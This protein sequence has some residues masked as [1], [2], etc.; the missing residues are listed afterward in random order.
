VQYV[1]VYRET[2]DIV[3]AGPAGDWRTDEENHI[4]STESGQPVCR[5]DDLVVVLRK[6]TSAR[7]ANFGCMI[8]PRQDNLAK[9]QEF[10]AKSAQTTIRSE[11]RRAW[12]EGL[13]SRLGKQD[14][15]VYGLDP[16]TRVARVMVEADYRMKLV[17]MGLEAGVP[18]VKSYLAS[19][20]VPAGQSPPPMGVLRWWF[21]LNYDALLASQDHQAFALRGQ[22]VKVLSENERLTAAGQRVHTGQSEALCLQFARSFTEHFE[23]LCVKYPIYADLRNIFDLALVAALVREEDLGNKVGWHMVSFGNPKAYAV[24]RGPAPKEV[25]SVMNHRVINGIHVVAGVSGGVSV[26]PTSLVTSNSMEVDQSRKLSG[27]Q[28][29]SA[30]KPQLGTDAWWW[31]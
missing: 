9:V 2:G 1:F 5:L 22:G 31:D 3:L 27:Q 24:E 11:D 19:I 8:N 13:R 26:H 12:L 18:G 4:V 30:P 10:L 17:G 21:T 28:S 20:Q 15:E 29:Y 14:I 7:D 23:E 25:D 16:S 6:M